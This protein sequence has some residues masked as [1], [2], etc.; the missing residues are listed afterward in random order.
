MCSKQA[1]HEAYSKIVKSCYGAVSHV[2]YQSLTSILLHLD[3]IICFCHCWIQH[4]I[5]GE[6]FD[7]W[8]GVRSQSSMLEI[9]D[10]IHLHPV[11]HLI[12]LLLMRTEFISCCTLKLLSKKLSI[13]ETMFDWFQERRVWKASAGKECN[14]MLWRS[15]EKLPQLGTVIQFHWHAKIMS[16]VRQQ[17]LFANP[18]CCW[19][20]ATTILI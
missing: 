2:A 20:C 11:E 15:W 8:G 17:N 4:A 7:F 6:E 18:C 5:V 3:S 16:T 13:Q 14:R 19:L 10:G 1:L 12:K 9:G